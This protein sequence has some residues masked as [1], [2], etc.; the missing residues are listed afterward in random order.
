MGDLFPERLEPTG[1]VPDLV[2]QEPKRQPESGRRRRPPPSKEADPAPEA[3]V[4]P[5]EVDSLA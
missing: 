5:H 4:A 3:D 2:G 1:R